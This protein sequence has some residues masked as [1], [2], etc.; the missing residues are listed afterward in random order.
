VLATVEPQALFLDLVGAGHLPRDFVRLV[1]RFRWGTGIFTIHAALDRLPSFRAEA[2]EGTLAY[3]LARS[4]QAITAGVVAARA[5]Q[6]PAH[7][8]L[9]AG[10]HTL[11]DPSRAP[12][13]KHTFWGM[14]HVPGEVR[15]DQAEGITASSWQE[16][17]EPFLARV[18]DEMELY[19]PGFRDAVLHVVGQTPEELQAE[20]PNLV[21]GDLGSGS[22]LLDQQLVFRPL[23]G[24]FRY[25]T[26]LAGLYISGA[27]THPGGGVHGAPGAN[28]ARVLLGDLRMESLTAP[29]Q[30]AARELSRL[31]GRVRGAAGHSIKLS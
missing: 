20:N 17:K 7:P 1:R 9:I 19:A 10:V 30:G 18:L 31:G 16:A 8:L 24:W 15:G 5:G 29:I 27:A 12:E 3:H 28:A 2:L 4:T 14:T 26:P 25:K 22:Y 21:G 13:G 11:I 6:L 23:P